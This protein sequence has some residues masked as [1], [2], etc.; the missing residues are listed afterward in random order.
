MSKSVINKT[1]GE[2]YHSIKEAEE[3]LNIYNITYNCQGKIDFVY[4]KDGKGLKIYEDWSYD[5]EN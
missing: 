1:T 5:N 2:R 3:K 4:V